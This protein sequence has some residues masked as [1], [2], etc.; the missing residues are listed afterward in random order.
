M[1][2]KKTCRQM[3]HKDVNCLTNGTCLTNGFH[4]RI[5][6]EIVK[7]LNLQYLSIPPSPSLGRW[8][9]SSG[10]PPRCSLRR[11][12]SNDEVPGYQY[13]W[14]R[15]TISAFSPPVGEKKITKLLESIS[16]LLVKKNFVVDFIPHDP[17]VESRWTRSDSDNG[18]I[19][20][21]AIIS[22]VK[23]PPVLISRVTI[24]AGWTPVITRYT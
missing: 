15:L 21:A 20:T 13:P 14:N 6:C 9:G 10:I 1:G 5:W 12:L 18:E 16:S 17:H 24:F 8:D 19:I 11:D 2:R 3:E 23:N 7:Q 4:C 22:W